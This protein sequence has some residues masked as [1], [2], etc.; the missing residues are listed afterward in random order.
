MFRDRIEE[1]NLFNVEERGKCLHNLPSQ[2]LMLKTLD[3]LKVQNKIK[4]EYASAS[5]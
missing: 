1:N 3:K 2:R 5:I 4:C